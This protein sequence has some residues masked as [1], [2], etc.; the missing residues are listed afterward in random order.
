MAYTVISN[1]RSETLAVSKTLKN[2]AKQESVYCVIC[3]KQGPNMESV[4]LN[5]V[6]ILGHFLPRVPDPQQHPYTKTWVKCTPPPGNNCHVSA[7]TIT[8]NCP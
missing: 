4:V 5:W 8:E 3:P 1:P 7:I 6:G 2:C